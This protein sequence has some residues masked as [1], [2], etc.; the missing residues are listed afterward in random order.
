M[1][2]FYSIKSESVVFYPIYKVLEFYVVWASSNFLI[3]L[4]CFSHN[5]GLS[6]IQFCNDTILMC[7]YTFVMLLDKKIQGTHL[8]PIREELVSY[9][10]ELN[11]IA[12]IAYY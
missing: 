9:I 2:S 8:N 3:F 5:K 6:I 11:A 1:T 4:V 7:N 10:D 12:T